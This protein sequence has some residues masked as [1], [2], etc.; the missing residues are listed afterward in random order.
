M[1]VFLAVTLITQKVIDDFD[2]LPDLCRIITGKL[3]YLVK[4][5]GHR[6]RSQVKVKGDKNIKSDCFQAVS[7]ITQKVIGRF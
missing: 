7:S 5:I 1:T 4:K 3:S 2:V 6:S